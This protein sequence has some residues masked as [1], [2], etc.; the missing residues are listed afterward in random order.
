MKLIGIDEEK[1]INCGKCVKV[2]PSLLF[3]E[4]EENKDSKIKYTFSD[5]NDLCV[6]CGHCIAIC[7]PEAID[8]KEADP[9]FNFEGTKKLQEIASYETIQKLLRMRRSIRNFKQE[10]I[11]KEKIEKLLE[12]MRYAPSASNRQNWRYIVLTNKDEI[13]YLSK[14]TAKFFKTARKVL[15][16]RYLVAPFLNPGARRRALNP[17]SKIQL[18]RGITRMEQ[19]EDIVFF[20]APC[21]II[22]YSRP[23]ANG[24]AENDA[25]IA[26]TY[27][28]I[29]AQSLGLGTCWIGF[30]QRRMQ[31]NRKLRKHYK[32]P[33]GFN[34]FGVLAV[35]EPTIQYQR[36]PPR[37]ELRVK[38]YE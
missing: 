3:S 26:L 27:G 37:R 8:Y 7:P 5:P 36:G 15:P 1:C 29:T 20:N 14:K 19:G 23:Y 18:D 13:N 6:Q 25:G 10:E 11:P 28:M 34:V 21:V 33:R 17:K 30:V 9:P 38:W 2:C 4:K 31:N 12:A 24:L 16:L 22:L 35:G 32:I